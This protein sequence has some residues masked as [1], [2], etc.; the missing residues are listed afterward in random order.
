M[1]HQQ[2]AI[3]G[4]VMVLL[5][6]LAALPALAHGS[7]DNSIHATLRADVLEI[8]VVLGADAANQVLQHAA[9]DMPTTLGGAGQK[10]L[11]VAFAAHFIEVKSGTA[12][13]V[14]NQ[15]CTVGDG[16]EYMFTATFPAL[17]PAT[18]TFRAP[19]FDI[20][21]QMKLGTLVLGDDAGKQIGSGLLTRGSATVELTLPT[22]ATTEAAAPANSTNQ[23][24]D[25]STPAQIQPST[26]AT[27]TP[28]NA[29][30]PPTGRFLLLGVEHNPT[31]YDHLLLLCALLV[32][33]VLSSVWLRQRRLS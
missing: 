8:S 15:F 5:P 20:V 27:A 3:H 2:R 29:Q 23:P 33:V 9:P 14:A 4:A 22:S 1:P 17:A 19:Y 18:L 7:F 21:E 11:P 26:A 25:F 28:T 6:C 16:I 30:R 13:L 10:Q 32:V 24:L 31:G 12:I